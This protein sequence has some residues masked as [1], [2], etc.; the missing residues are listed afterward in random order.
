MLRDALLFLY[1]SVQL[2]QLTQPK[3]C[4]SSSIRVWFLPG[5]VDA[6]VFDQLLSFATYSRSLFFLRAEGTMDSVVC[7]P[8]PHTRPRV[9]WQQ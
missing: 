9:W 1:L 4:V 8:V 5:V 7:S 6:T 3:V 2:I